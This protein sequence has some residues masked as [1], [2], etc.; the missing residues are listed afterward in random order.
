MP[1]DA[2]RRTVTIGGQE[3]KILQLASILG[4]VGLMLTYVL[5]WVEIVD[6]VAPAEQ[7]DQPVHDA[8]ELVDPVNEGALTGFDIGIFPEL[9]VLCGLVVVGLSLY[10]WERWTHLAVTF[11]GLAGTATALFTREF[12]RSEGWIEI[13]SYVGFGSAFETAY[14]LWV[15][16]LVSA[17]LIGVGFGGF[18]NSFDAKE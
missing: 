7:A 17:L 13:G 11:V 6:H 16:L 1:G 8:D 15:L 18:L 3:F 2:D 9:M 12:V 5:P 14:G 10:R 4:G